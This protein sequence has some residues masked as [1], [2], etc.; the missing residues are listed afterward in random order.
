M[1]SGDWWE[2]INRGTADVGIAGGTPHAKRKTLPVTRILRLTTCTVQRPPNNTYAP[3]IPIA[4]LVHLP[5]FPDA[6]PQGLVQQWAETV[7]CETLVRSLPVRSP[8]TGRD[9][10]Q[11]WSLGT[12]SEIRIPPRRPLLFVV[13][14][15][16]YR[17]E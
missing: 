17:D 5:R 9:A 8:D 14:S 2:Y 12:I 11:L 13:S 6:M 7:H 16:S 15:S 3:L 1:A 10:R 4:L